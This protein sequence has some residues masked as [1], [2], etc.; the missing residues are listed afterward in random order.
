MQKLQEVIVIKCK[1]RF[2]QPQICQ[3]FIFLLF[4][5]QIY[6]VLM[7][8]DDYKSTEVWTIQRKVDIMQ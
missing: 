8:I 2:L 4:C 5:Y 3:G 6:V 7:L 1:L